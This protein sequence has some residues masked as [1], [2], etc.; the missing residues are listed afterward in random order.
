MENRAHAVAAGIFTIVLGLAAAF[1]VWWFSGN[2]EATKE[3]V[4][5]TT[6]SVTGLNAQATV[7]YR[8]I[9]AGRVNAIGLDPNDARNILVTIE[10]DSDIPVTRSTTARLATQGVTGLAYV[11]LED[12]GASNEG[13]SGELARIPMTGSAT[14]ALA[15][16]AVDVLAQTRTLL[17]RMEGLLD[18]ENL[19]RISVTLK[20]LESASAGLDQRVRDLGPLLADARRAFDD[21][22]ISRL[23][24]ILAN[25]EKASGQA[26]PIANELRT[27]LGSLQ[28]VAR[29]LDAA[30]ADAAG[31]FVGNTLPRANSLLHELATTSRQL[32][33]VLTELEDA[34]QSLVFGRVPP[35]PGPGEAGFQAPKSA[36][37]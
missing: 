6:N 14:D 12:S 8:G 34:P 28:A 21:K 24:T 29:R 18:D 37:Q 32:T 27:L 26:T 30:G 17:A 33:R 25:V 20:N 4:L 7:R 23:R 31:E 9:R 11:Q 16:T 1:A 5:V 10:I 3:Y 36:R 35:R 22:N 19:A 2:R 13:L 15:D